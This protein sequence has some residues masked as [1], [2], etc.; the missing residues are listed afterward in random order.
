MSASLF[1]AVVVLFAGSSA[2][3]QGPN[4]HSVDF[5][6]RPTQPGSWLLSAAECGLPGN[7]NESFHDRTCRGCSEEQIAELPFIVYLSPERP[8]GYTGPRTN[9]SNDYRHSRATVQS[10]QRLCVSSA[11]QAD[12]AITAFQRGITVHHHHDKR[13]GRAAVAHCRLTD[14]AAVPPSEGHTV[15]GYELTIEYEAESGWGLFDFATAQRCS[16]S[17]L[18]RA[19]AAA[20]DPSN[21]VFSA[22]PSIVTGRGGGPSDAFVERFI[23]VGTWVDR[24]GISST[25]WIAAI[26]IVLLS[27]GIALATA[28]WVLV[29]LS[30]WAYDALKA[31]SG[32]RDGDE[33]NGA[34][35]AV[36]PTPRPTV[37]RTIRQRRA[38][39]AEAEG[40]GPR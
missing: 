19:P 17:L 8:A 6:D 36:M 11:A 32:I 2:A 14:S 33:V 12:I 23:A 30:S 9:G 40:E 21:G 28:T 18:W 1:V 4:W 39:G 20:D 25:E 16:V 10:W 31:L 3:T 24:V 5:G 15:A 22:L 26:G 27:L 37:Q 13:A 34:V 38:P 29:Q 7:S 35:S